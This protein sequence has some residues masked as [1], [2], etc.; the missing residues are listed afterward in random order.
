MRTEFLKTDAET[1]AAAVS[2]FS[3]LV[4]LG[5]LWWNSR[6]QRCLTVHVT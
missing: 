4:Q 6:L 2:F 1:S 5:N 3:D